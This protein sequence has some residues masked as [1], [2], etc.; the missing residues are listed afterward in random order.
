MKNTRGLIHNTKVSPNKNQK[1]VSPKKA[2][3]EQWYVILAI[4]VC[5]KRLQF[6]GYTRP[7]TRH[8]KQ[9]LTPTPSG[10]L[11]LSKTVKQ[12]TKKKGDNKLLLYGP[13]TVMGNL[14]HRLLLRC[15]WDVTWRD[16]NHAN[17]NLATAAPRWLPASM[18][19]IYTSLHVWIHLLLD[20]AQATLNQLSVQQCSSSSK[21]QYA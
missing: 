10:V 19:I 18:S 11:P 9:L 7:T 2:N 17:T 8:V 15:Y 1:H 16:N 21:F 6:L 20:P 5:H 3:D 13:C 12:K 14:H 4:P